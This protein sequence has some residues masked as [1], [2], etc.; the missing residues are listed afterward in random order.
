MVGEQLGEMC[1]RGWIE[2]EEREWEREAYRIH[3]GSSVTTSPGVKMAG[4]CESCISS[5][6][7]DCEDCEESLWSSGA[8]GARGVIVK[9]IE[10]KLL[11]NLEGKCEARDCGVV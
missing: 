3:C 7:P 2:V 10:G 5:S 8:E 4:W 11:E 9:V 1:V 6:D